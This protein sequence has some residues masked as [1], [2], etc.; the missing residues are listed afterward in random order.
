MQSKQ[1]THVQ[2]TPKN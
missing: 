1:H 2:V